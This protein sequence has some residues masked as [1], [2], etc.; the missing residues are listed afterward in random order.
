MSSLDRSDGTGE[1]VYSTSALERLRRRRQAAQG[2][3]DRYGAELTVDYTPVV[4]ARSARGLQ[5]SSS[6]L[7]EQ[8]DER[9]A[10]ICIADRPHGPPIQSANLHYLHPSTTRKDDRRKN[11]AVQPA[12]PR[13]QNSRRAAARTGNYPQ[14]SCDSAATTR[15]RAARVVA[16]TVGDGL[17]L[18]SGDLGAARAPTTRPVNARGKGC[19]R[20][21]QSD[22]D[23]PRPRPGTS[24][25]SWSPTY[26]CRSQDFLPISAGQPPIVVTTDT[27]YLHPGEES[28]V[29]R[30]MIQHHSTRSEIQQARSTHRQ[31]TQRGAATTGTGQGPK[32]TGEIPTSSVRRTQISC[33]APTG[34]LF[35]PPAIGGEIPLPGYGRSGHRGTRPPADKM[36]IGI[37]TEF[38]LR[39]KQPSPPRSTF[40]QFAQCI[41]TEHNRYMDGQHPRMLSDVLNYGPRQR[42]DQW[43]LITDSSM[44]THWE[45]CKLSLLQVMTT[46]RTSRS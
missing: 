44:S 30:S 36:G 14:A 19:P 4:T 13:Q 42:F 34:H 26:Q 2:H 31:I 32:T 27:T 1:S 20:A 41:A 33:I 6:D 23:A 43:A 11:L 28:G 39:A 24:G 8:Q 37:E 45:P 7:T 17:R 9:L 46:I 18:S 40:A 35:F 38:L 29:R 25:I 12:A 3:G 16:A 15:P 21:F 22:L 5:I 10:G